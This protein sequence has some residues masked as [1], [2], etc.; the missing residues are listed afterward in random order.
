MTHFAF[1]SYEHAVRYA[2]HIATQIGYRP[3]LANASGKTPVQIDDS[4]SGRANFVRCVLEMGA[5]S[6][7][8][9][10]DR[11][12]ALVAYAEAMAAEMGGST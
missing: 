11:A 6:A 1:D 4:P 7:L 3:L 8:Q 5:N 12:R 9:I 10:E 2:L